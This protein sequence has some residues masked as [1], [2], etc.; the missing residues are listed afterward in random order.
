V[1]W[2]MDRMRPALRTAGSA[3]YRWPL[4][5]TPPKRSHQDRARAW[6]PWPHVGANESRRDLA[7]VPGNPV[8]AK[9]G[10]KQLSLFR[11]DSSSVI[12]PMKNE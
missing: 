1:R 11:P 3:D 2:I 4:P 5:K 6:Q 9:I 7:G 12:S 8:A 10:T